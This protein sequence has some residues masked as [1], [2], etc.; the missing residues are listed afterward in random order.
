MRFL[1][2]LIL[3]VGCSDPPAPSR[4]GHT[5]LV[6]HP[7]DGRLYEAHVCVPDGQYCESANDCFVD[8]CIYSQCVNKH[9]VSWSYPDGDRCFTNTIEL[10]SCDACRCLTEAVQ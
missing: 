7:Y 4:F 3:A 10:G 1:F 5:F 2:V 9:C 6:N 8:Q